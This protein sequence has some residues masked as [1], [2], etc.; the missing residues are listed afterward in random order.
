MTQIPRGP[1]HLYCPF[2]KKRMSTVCHTCPMWQML[3][4]VHPQ[5]GEP[6]P[7]EWNCSLGHITKLLI[8][9]AQQ[10]RQAGASA[11][12]VATEVAKF[13]QKMVQMNHVASAQLALEKHDDRE[14]Q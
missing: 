12:K 1:D 8:E 4:G 11:D 7:D 6:I 13:H 10:S 3:R 2:W 14:C 5:T 9:G